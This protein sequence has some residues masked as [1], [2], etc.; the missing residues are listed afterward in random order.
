MGSQPAKSLIQS[1]SSL[2]P[3]HFRQGESHNHKMYMDK[4]VKYRLF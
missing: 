3:A 2:W 1:S 4:N